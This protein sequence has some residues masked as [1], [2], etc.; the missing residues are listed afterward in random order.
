[1]GSKLEK[2]AASDSYFVLVKQFPLRSIRNDRHLAQAQ[3]VIDRLLQKELD[4]GEQDY[5][6]ALSD[7][8]ESY[9]EAHIEIPDASEADVLHELMRQHGLNQSKL[10]KEVGIS[11][12]TISAVLAGAR[13]LTRGQIESLAAYFAVSPA[14]FMRR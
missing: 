3:Q 9:E 5:L 14:A 13:T 7:L 12:S 10:T 6:D 2:S 11:Q 8:I 4:E 1:M